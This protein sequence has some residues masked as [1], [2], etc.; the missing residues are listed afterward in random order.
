VIDV[1]SP[2]STVGAFWVSNRCTFLVSEA[3]RSEQEGDSRE[4]RCHISANVC[5][6]RA[7]NGAPSRSPTNDYAVTARL[8]LHSRLSLY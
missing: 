5:L 3:Q 4:A 7:P 2:D 8:G 6:G 1:E